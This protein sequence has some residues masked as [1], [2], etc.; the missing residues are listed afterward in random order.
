MLELWL[1]NKQNIR[2]VETAFLDC[3]LVGFRLI[4]NRNSCYSLLKLSNF[5]AQFSTAK[6][7]PLVKLNW[8]PLH[9]FRIL[10]FAAF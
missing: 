6:E 10:V 3:F 2:K 8:V 7:S 9:Y 5:I 4:Q 1:A